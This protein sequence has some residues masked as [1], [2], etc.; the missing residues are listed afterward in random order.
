MRVKIN[1]S[2]IGENS[3]LMCRSSSVFLAFNKSS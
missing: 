2:V 3:I 1:R